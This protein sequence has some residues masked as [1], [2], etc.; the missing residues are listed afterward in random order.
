MQLRSY[1]LISSWTLRGTQALLK[2][3]PKTEST[4]NILWTLFSLEM[5][6]CYGHCWCAAQFLYRKREVAAENRFYSIGCSPWEECSPWNRELSFTSNKLVFPCTS[7]KRKLHAPLSPS[8]LLLWFWIFSAHLWW[9]WTPCWGWMMARTAL[10]VL[11][12]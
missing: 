4:F 7:K 12:C 1:L 2:V 11:W 5:K 3:Q 9:V 10:R 8:L 6:W